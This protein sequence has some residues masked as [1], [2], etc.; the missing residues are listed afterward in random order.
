MY[1]SDNPCGPNYNSQYI[2]NSDQCFI[3]VLAYCK[4][5]SKP[6]NNTHIIFFSQNY[7]LTPGSSLFGEVLHQCKIRQFSKLPAID[8]QTCNRS[9]EPVNTI[10]NIETSDLGTEPYR[11]C[12]CQGGLF[13]CSFQPDVIRVS[14]GKKFSV[15][16][17]AVDQVNNLVNATIHSILSRTGGGLGD[18]VKNIKTQ[19]KSVLIQN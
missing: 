16:L 18:M 9:N 3:Q 8:N 1:I 17:V 7:A 2:T 13:D 4:R 5:C 14:K 15:Q 12:F 11:L 19:V 6:P 10:S